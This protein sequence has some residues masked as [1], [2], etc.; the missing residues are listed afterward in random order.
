[1]KLRELLLRRLWLMPV[2]ASVIVASPFTA[3]AFSNA[4][5]KGGFGC[6]GTLHGTLGD[7]TELMQLNFNGAARVTGSVHVLVSGEDCL[8]SVGSSSGYSTNKDGTG[9]LTLNLSFTGSD[10]TQLSSKFGTQEV[11]FVLERASMVFDFAG[12][13]DS[14]S[15]RSGRR[16]TWSSFTGSCTGQGQF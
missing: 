1:M 11:D 3:Q 10:C 2:V 14:F 5:L 8:A 12:Q 15:T 13:D 16:S 6:L 4:D 9:A 7:V